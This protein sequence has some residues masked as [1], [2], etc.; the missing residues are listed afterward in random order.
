LLDEA[1]AAGWIESGMT[2]A[3]GG[4]LLSSHPM[5]L[6]RRIVQRGVRDL[7]V[8]GSPSAGLDIDILIAAGCVKKLITAYVGGEGI[9][10]VGPAYKAALEA[11][12]LKLWECDESMFYAALRAGAQGLPSMPS[13]GL[14]GTSYPELNTE[15]VPYSDPITGEPLLAVPAIRADIA[16][17][18][19]SHADVYGN[20]QY[21]GSGF[22]DRAMY[23]AADRTIV[24][25][26]RIVPVEEIRKDPLR[27]AIPYADAVVRAPFGSHPFA[28][29]GYYVEDTAHLSGYVE[30]ARLA[31]K[32]DRGRLDAY[33]RTYLTGPRDHVEYLETVGMRRL[34]A[35]HEY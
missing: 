9:V 6:I 3:I 13:K 12:S 11:G 23:N 18:H 10:A 26:E 16:I 28:S 14:I 7:T 1:E 21:V 8:I 15:L 24:Q 34:L 22:G 5:A 31:A 17:L 35:L 25:V 2:I 4:L 30:V 32:S 33:L 27:T 29:P 20:I 19:A